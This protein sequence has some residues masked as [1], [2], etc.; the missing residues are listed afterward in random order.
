MSVF[1]RHCT[2]C[3]MLHM[4]HWSSKVQQK[5]WRRV[6][7]KTDGPW[8]NA[9]VNTTT[10]SINDTLQSAVMTSYDFMHFL[11]SNAANRQALIVSTEAVIS[12]T[13]RHVPYPPPLAQ[14]RPRSQKSGQ[15]GGSTPTPCLDKA[16]HAQG[17]GGYQDAQGPLSTSV[18]RCCKDV[19]GGGGP[20]LCPR[21][22][23]CFASAFC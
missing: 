2:L 9:T 20:A 17:G 1:H 15:N 14:A 4:L 12:A 7:T 5:P 21:I 23:T 10:I 3:P 8:S 6:G 19:G 18:G 11:S 22:G 16:V 13:F